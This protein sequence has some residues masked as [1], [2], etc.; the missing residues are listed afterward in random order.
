MPT[1][2]FEKGYDKSPP[3]VYIKTFGCPYVQVPTDDSEAVK[4]GK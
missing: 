4:E 2:E 1:N 3:K